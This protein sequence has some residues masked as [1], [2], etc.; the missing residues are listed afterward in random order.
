[1][2]ENVAVT[3]EAAEPERRKP[4]FEIKI[5]SDQLSVFVRI[6][7]SF[8]L[9][10]VTVEEADVIA[11]LE[12]N[13]IKHGIVNDEI[14]EFCER[15]NFH[16]W[17]KVAFGTQSVDG[18]NGTY[19]LTFN[20]DSS[21]PQERE[22]GTVDYR[23][24]GVIKNVFQSEVLCKLTLPTPGTDGTNV[25]GGVI[26]A[27]AG[28]AAAIDI[29]N[30][31]SVTGDKTEFLATV[32][33]CVY[34]KQGKV[35]VEETYIVKDDVSLK[36]GNVSFNG[37][38]QIAANVLQGFKVNAKNDIFV[39]GRVEGAELTA[40]GNIV[41]AGGITGMNTAKI[42][43]GGDVAAKFIENATV[44]CGG[45]V[46]CDILLMSTVKAEKG[47]IMKGQ[48]AAII[49]G[50]SLAG[51]KI[52][53][54]S[55]GSDKF[56]K[57][58][59]T[60]AKNWRMKEEGDEESE[61]KDKVDIAAIKKKLFTAQQYYEMFDKKVRDESNLGPAKSISALK[62]YMVK[63]SEFAAVVSSL[64]KLLES[65]KEEDFMTSISC[66]GFIYPGVKLCIDNC[67]LSITETMQNQ[68][69]YVHEGE[70][71]AGATLPSDNG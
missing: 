46:S 17:H 51:E 35:Y 16:Q 2:E 68:K 7:S 19:S 62:D 29:G 28:K 58:E 22:D 5:P 63:K 10:G 38:I 23:E 40:G 11:L 41:I 48:R 59:V 34:F 30:N 4:E 25:Y 49:G 20:P 69:F 26:P 15:K 8:D 18:E 64:E 54:K 36:T 61:D 53:C 65:F 56:I 21:G 47:I 66:T 52:V 55:L 3:P 39:K 6:P 45:N 71:V 33:G 14:K 43:A 32:D 24:L 27:K 60:V 67:W 37:S 12:K 70:I 57:Q 13:A 31:V 1:M 50:H 44:I 9:Q 42:D